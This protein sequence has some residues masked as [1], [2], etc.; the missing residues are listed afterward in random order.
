MTTETIAQAIVI[1]M[2]I[3]GFAIVCGKLA[4]KVSDNEKDIIEVKED[5]KE[6]RESVG[7]SIKEQ[8]QS[9]TEILKDHVEAEKMREVKVEAIKDQLQ[10][11]VKDTVR[12]EQQ[13]IQNQKQTQELKQDM[14]IMKKEIDGIKETTND[15][16]QDIAVL[17]TQMAAL[18]KVSTKTQD[19]VAEILA[20]ARKH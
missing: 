2:S 14:T 4:Q 3:I 6:L 20:E 16:K 10:T 15:I 13:T 1:L 19:T 17:S 8:A 7:T 5:T 12:L 11:Y 18:V 9:F